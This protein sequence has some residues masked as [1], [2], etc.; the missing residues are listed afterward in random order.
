MT[1]TSSSGLGFSRPTTPL[2]PSGESSP[3]PNNF[4][5]K[6]KELQQQDRQAES[7][8]MRPSNAF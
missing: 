7:Y 1:V 8:D 5:M 2:T 3:L 4:E 6:E